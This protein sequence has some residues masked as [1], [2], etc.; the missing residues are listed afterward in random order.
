MALSV[1]CKADSQVFHLNWSLLLVKPSESRSDVCGMCVRF[2][3]VILELGGR[4]K[5]KLFRSEASLGLDVSSGP[6]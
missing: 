5:L 4:L 3:P 1:C 6:A 2:T